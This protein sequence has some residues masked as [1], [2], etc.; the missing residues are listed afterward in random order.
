MYPLFMESAQTCRRFKC[1]F[2]SGNL[3]DKYKA[4]NEAMPGDENSQLPATT[5]GSIILRRPTQPLGLTDKIKKD[6]KLHVPFP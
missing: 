2:K 1:H 5:E 3:C 4:F 6:T